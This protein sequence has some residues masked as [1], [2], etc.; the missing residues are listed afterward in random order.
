MKYLSYRQIIAVAGL[1]IFPLPKTDELGFHIV[2]LAFSH[3]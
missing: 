1:V 2:I 3:E